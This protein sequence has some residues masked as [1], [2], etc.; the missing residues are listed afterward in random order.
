MNN[1]TTDVISIDEAKSLPGLFQERVRR[2][3][4]A[5]AY[6]YYDETQSRWLTYS[7]SEAN[8]QILSIQAAL[9]KEG[10]QPGDHVALML[11][12]CPQWV[13]FEQAALGIG[14][15]VVPL[16]TND[17]ADNVSYVLQDAGVKLL[18]VEDESS[19]KQLQPIASQLQGLLRL[20]SVESCN[21]TPLYPR[22]V[23]LT[24]WKLP[25]S[26]APR[27]PEINLDALAT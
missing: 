1:K 2:T 19:L 23:S 7:W 9:A 24:D 25:E 18:L 12:N 17:R 11:R 21:E 22:L 13:F 16:Y 27:L 8:K 26:E 5:T 14:L 15:V 10:L 6:R 20:I 4:A 3:P